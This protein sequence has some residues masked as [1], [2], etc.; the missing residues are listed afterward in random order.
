MSSKAA[1]AINRNPVSKNKN[2]T[3]LP[4]KQKPY[5]YTSILPQ[6]TQNLNYN[7]KRGRKSTGPS[8]HLV[9]KDKALRVNIRERTQSLGLHRS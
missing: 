2:E 9:A 7:N 5:M 6:I 1:K 8:Y 3:L 4:P